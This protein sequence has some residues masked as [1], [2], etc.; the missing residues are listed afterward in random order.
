[1]TNM[2]LSQGELE[3]L[4]LQMAKWLNSQ[5]IRIGGASSHVAIWPFGHFAESW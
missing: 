4:L 1:M 3:T 5:C 2:Y